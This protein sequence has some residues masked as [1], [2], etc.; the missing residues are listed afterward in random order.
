MKAYATSIIASLAVAKT[1][2]EWKQRSVYQLL[3]DRFMPS[4]DTTAPCDNLGQY[5]GGTFKGIRHHL[6]Y[7][8]GMGFDAIWISPIPK[9]QHP[10]DYHGYGAMDWESVNDYFGSN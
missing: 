9:N 8:Q 7:I 3:T 6:D 2:E 10:Y 4:E 1:T 5:C